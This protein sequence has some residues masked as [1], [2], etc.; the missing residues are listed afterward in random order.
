MTS[1][2]ATQFESFSMSKNQN[3]E[4]DV[5]LRLGWRLGW[6][7]IFSH[8]PW[9]IQLLHSISWSIA[10]NLELELQKLAQQLLP[11]SAIHKT[12]GF[13][14]INPQ[15]CWQSSEKNYWKK[16]SLTKR[17]ICP[18]SL[19]LLSYKLMCTRLIGRQSRWSDMSS[20]FNKRPSPWIHHLQQ[21]QHTLEIVFA[22]K[23]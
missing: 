3:I 14:W 13:S 15:W 11:M 9:W 4:I 1:H 19:C 21:L 2:L 23:T 5:P 16:K 18:A 10:S 7:M 17:L 22:Q 8:C 6:N 12:T 20:N